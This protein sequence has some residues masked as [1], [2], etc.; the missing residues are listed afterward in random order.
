MR[1]G[2]SDGFMALHPCEGRRLACLFIAGD[3][4]I[5]AFPRAQEVEATKL[6]HQLHRLVDHA[7]QLIV[8]AKLD[9]AGER[10]VLTQGMTLE[11][12]IGKQAPQIRVAGEQDPVKVVRLALEPIGG[13]KDADRAWHRR[14]LVGLH[15]NAEPAVMPGT[16]Q[17]IDNSN[18]C[19]RSG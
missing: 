17:M 15:A 10:K 18:R 4:G 2:I 16:E 14:L 6:L 7:L 13:G 11:A 12:V 9:E 8:V 5:H 19:S 1:P 3:G